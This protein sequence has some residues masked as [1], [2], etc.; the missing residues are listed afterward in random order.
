MKTKKNKK[1]DLESKRGLFFEIGMIT[2]LLE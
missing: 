2:I 1:A